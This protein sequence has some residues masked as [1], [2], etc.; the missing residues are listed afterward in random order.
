MTASSPPDQPRVTVVLPVWNAGDFLA[1][2]VESIRAQTLADWQLLAIDDGSTDGSRQTLEDF[3]RRDRRIVVTSRPNRG[4]AATLQE[5]IERA[6]S[7]IVAL[8]N[9]DDISHPDRLARQFAFLEHHPTV[10]ALG[11]QTRLLVDGRATTIESRLPLAPEACRR[12]LPLAPPLAHPTVMLRR[13]AVLAVGGYRPQSY[14]E[15]Y[16]LWLRLAD[17]VDLA[18]LPAALLD[19]RLHDGQFSSARDEKVA[20]ATLVVRAAAA[21]R[22]SGRPDRVTADRLGIRVADIV[23]QVRS[24]ALG[25]AEQ[26]LAATG[27]FK[28]AERELALLDDHW[29]AAADPRRWQAAHDWLTGRGLLVRGDRLGALRSL[30]QAAAA[31]P[32]LARRLAAAAIRRRQD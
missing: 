17:R 15:D 10:A 6:R 25:R 31:D 14:V 1:A 22:R 20:V 2:A 32:A 4:L 16:D 18:N 24:A 11:T 3:A 26:V 27:S 28:R 30:A 9:A 29:T 8:M 7:G 21:A 23:A 12:F 19:Y 5:G 13:D